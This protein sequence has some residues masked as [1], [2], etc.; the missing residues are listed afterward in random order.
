MLVL[1]LAT[2]LLLFVG[3]GTGQELMRVQSIGPEATVE[4]LDEGVIR[5]LAGAREILRDALGVGPEVPIPA[6][7]R[8]ARINADLSTGRLSATPSMRGLA[9]RRRPKAKM[10]RPAQNT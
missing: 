9:I 4:R 3:V 1:V 6:D 2:V 7:E 8:L 5:R 10:S